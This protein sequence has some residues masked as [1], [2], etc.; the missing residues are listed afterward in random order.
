MK[1]YS[2]RIG[3][4]C[5]NFIYAEIFLY[6]I[7]SHLILETRRNFVHSVRVSM[8]KRL[9]SRKHV[10]QPI[11]RRIVKYSR[12]RSKSVSRDSRF[13]SRFSIF[14]LKNAEIARSTK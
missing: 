1:C 9:S 2:T 8:R 10:F 4:L 7:K 12:P 3:K 14:Q 13:V 5:R 11:Q 6:L